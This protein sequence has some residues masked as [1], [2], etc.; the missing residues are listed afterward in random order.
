[1]T[2]SSRNSSIAQ[3]AV[4]VGLAVMLVTSG[5]AFAG[6]A[7]GQQDD[8]TV[9]SHDLTVELSELPA[10][11]QSRPVTITV[12]DRLVGLVSV[13]EVTA[14]GDGLSAGDARLVDG[15]DADGVAETVV[16]DVRASGGGTVEGS[17]TVTVVGSYAGFGVSN[18]A[19]VSVDAPGDSVRFAVDGGDPL[20]AAVRATTDSRALD[21]VDA[22]SVFAVSTPDGAVLTDLSASLSITDG[23]SLSVPLSRHGG[24]PDI[25]VSPSSLTFEANTTAGTV[26]ITNAGTTALTIDAVELTGN[27]SAFD[28]SGSVDGLGPGEEST[29]AV[30]YIGEDPA[31]ATLL[32]STNAT[33]DRAVSLSAVPPDD[34]SDDAESDQSS[35]P[36]ATVSVSHEDGRT[37]MNASVRNA[38]A[39]ESVS[40]DVEDDPDRDVSVQNVS[41][42]P[43]RDGDF[44]LNLTASTDPPESMPSID[45]GSKAILGYLNVEHSIDNAAI[46]E[47]AMTVRVRKPRIESLSTTDP[48]DVVLLRHGPSGWAEQETTLVDET[49]D[50]Y[51]YRVVADGF[52]EWATAGKQAAFRI[53]ET[54]VNVS[55]VRVE[56]SIAVRVRITNTGGA[57]GEYEAELLL[58]DV[59]VENRTVAI[60]ANG[61]GQVNFRRALEQAG[62]Y[63]VQVNDVVVDEVE[64][65]PAEDAD[66]GEDGDPPAS[67]DS[68]GDALPLPLL[69][70][71]GLILLALLGGAYV[72]R[73]D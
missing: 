10:D 1:M 45:D 46:S 44:T 73:S 70:V 3:S 26:T 19:S 29:L 8:A 48:D 21:L 63:E 28:V 66:T 33:T 58:N 9:V 2:H 59:V 47:A 37:S 51:V 30:S 27:A 61:T 36:D 17:V 43:E 16:V 6:I 13:S 49:R 20:I 22:P 55:S 54:S 24:W 11:G 50:H 60:A 14:S 69:G 42:T 18:P 7:S 32:V 31:N 67:S 57:D 15:P 40:I 71:G 68:D 38:T 39:G 35:D 41:L 64:V 34:A 25:A 52:S 65:A 4:L 56:E 62:T 53:V 72:Y 23:L 5:V 12:P